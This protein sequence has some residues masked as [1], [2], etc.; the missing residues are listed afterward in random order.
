MTDTERAS[1]VYQRKGRDLIVKLRRHR[2]DEDTDETKQGLDIH[3]VHQPFSIG[4][5]RKGALHGLS[6]DPG[7]RSSP[8]KTEALALKEADRPMGGADETSIGP[9]PKLM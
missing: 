7:S 9:A 2:C 5:D 6:T 4:Y 3:G 8:G 1:N